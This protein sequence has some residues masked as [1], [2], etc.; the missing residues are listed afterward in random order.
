MELH[1]RLFSGTSVR[2]YSI[3]T[4]KTAA[5][6]LLLFFTI[7][8]SSYVG[9]VS[10]SPETIS[11]IYMSQIPFAGSYFRQGFTVV[12]YNI[13][14]LIRE[15]EILGAVFVGAALG[16]GGAS[17][18][19]IFKNPITEPYIIGISSG[20]TLGAV[21][22]LATNS[23]ILGAYSVQLLAFVS[24]VAVVLIIYFLSFRSGKVPPIFLLLSGIAVSLFISAIVGLILF[25]SRRLQNEAFAWLLGSLSGITWGE[26]SVVAV[27][28]VVSGIIL[29]L[30]GKELDALQMGEA[31]AQSIG[32]HVERAKVIALMVTTVGVSAAV[33]ISGLIGFVGLII[34]HV[35]R[36]VYGGTN[37]KVV[38]MSAILGGIFLLVSN[39]LA[40]TV[41]HNE[42]IPVGI[43]TG[44]IGVPFFMYL[45]NRISR[46]NYVS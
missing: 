39:D 15:P 41:V 22:A 7:I 36:I 34:P 17:V 5:S 30:M 23:T 28:V 27:I 33:S 32:V 37:R 9:A 8:Y 31:H 3:F 19:S 2:K 4:V 40:R 29:S 6:L 13:V 21:V 46:G 38:P 12:Q 45:L 42:V 25:S 20:A 14:V 10:I 11:K 35:S 44:I 43:V 16:M 26:I 24:S 1:S 18:Q